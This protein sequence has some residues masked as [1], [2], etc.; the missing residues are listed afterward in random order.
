MKKSATAILDTLVVTK[1]THICHLQEQE[2][3][4]LWGPTKAKVFCL[5]FE[6]RTNR[7]FQ[8]SSRGV[9]TKVLTPPAQRPNFLLFPASSLFV[10]ESILNSIKYN[11]DIND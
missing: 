1:S 11:F 8:K 7:E 3:R 5:V 9:S 10:F 2:I 6:P 4:S